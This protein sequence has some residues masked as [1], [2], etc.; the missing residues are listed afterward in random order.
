MGGSAGDAWATGE[1]TTAPPRKRPGGRSARVRAAVLEATLTLMREAGDRFSI[2]QVAARAGVHETS[3]YRRWGSREALIV[4]AIRCYLGAEVP[5][6]DTG[7]LRGD[8]MAFI[9]RSV[10]FLRSSLGAQ[11]VRATAPASLAAATDERRHYWPHRLGQIGVMFERA[12]ARGEIADE[13]DSA[14]AA[15][16]LLAPLYFRLLVTGAPL[17]GDLAGRL[18]DFVL[19][20][21]E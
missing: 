5:V 12:L 9:E 4:D 6:P 16:L 13:A 14:L 3:I 11:L 20:G 8:L 10:A 2:A 19:W 1:E 7:S 21:L 15:E 17:D 18:A